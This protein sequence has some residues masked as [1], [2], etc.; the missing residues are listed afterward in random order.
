MRSGWSLQRIQEAD[1][2]QKYDQLGHSLPF[3][4]KESWIEQIYFSYIK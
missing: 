4:T 1:V 3:I 2:L